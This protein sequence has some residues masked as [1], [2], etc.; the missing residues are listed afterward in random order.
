MRTEAPVPLGEPGRRFALAGTQSSSLTEGQVQPGSEDHVVLPF[1]RRRIGY[2]DVRERHLPSQNLVELG[3]GPKVE[4]SP[5]IAA[6]VEVGKEVELF[7]QRRALS[8]LVH[9]FFAQS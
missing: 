9:D 7:I 3:D 8:Q 2:V 4:G 5:E 1:Q 6:A